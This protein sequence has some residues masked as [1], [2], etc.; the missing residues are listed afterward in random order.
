FSGANNEKEYR[1]NHGGTLCNDSFNT[2]ID[3]NPTDIPIYG[4]YCVD[5][6]VPT[7]WYHNASIT[8]EFG[9]NL[10][11][12]VGMRNIFDKRPPKVSTIGGVGVPGVIGPVVATSQYDFI[13][14]RMFF[15]VSPKF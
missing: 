12:T 6:K 7:A 8:K 3:G 4:H 2:D 14:R 15:S 13:G 5:V 1:A 9:K 11:F 10:E